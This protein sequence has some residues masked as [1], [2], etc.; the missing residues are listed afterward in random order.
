V[1]DGAD[2]TSAD[3]ILQ[4]TVIGSAGNGSD[5]IFHLGGLLLRESGVRKSLSGVQG[6]SPGTGSGGQIVFTD[7]D[8]RNDENLKIAHH[9]PPDY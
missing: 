1:S 6:Q 8:C 7:F 3:S 9:S 5:R 4:K 2:W